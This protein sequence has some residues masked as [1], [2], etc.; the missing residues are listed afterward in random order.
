MELGIATPAP[1]LRVL[2]PVINRDDP[3]KSGFR[4]VFVDKVV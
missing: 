4:Y 3:E 1:I 2:A